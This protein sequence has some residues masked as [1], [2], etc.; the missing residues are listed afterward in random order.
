MT[1]YF[2]IFKHWFQ[3]LT[4]NAIKIYIQINVTKSKKIT[5]HNKKFILFPPR[6]LPYTSYNSYSIVWYVQLFLNV[7]S[8]RC[9]N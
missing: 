4:H 9:A 2:S 6:I 5:V 1:S 3:L 8:K 7:Y